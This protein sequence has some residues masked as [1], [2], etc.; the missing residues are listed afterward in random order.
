MRDVCSISTDFGRR[1]GERAL[2]CVEGSK[3]AERLA[4][5]AAEQNE[6]SHQVLIEPVRCGGTI[7]NQKYILTA[8]HC[9]VNSQ[10]EILKAKDL[11]VIVGLNSLGL[12][13]KASN[14]KAVNKVIVH[15]NYPLLAENT[16]PH[17]Y[18][19]DIALLELDSKISLGATTTNTAL[20]LAEKDFKPWVYHPHGVVLGL[21]GNRTVKGNFKFSKDACK[22]GIDSGIHEQILCVGDVNEGKPLLGIRD[23]GFPVI[24]RKNLGVPVL[25]GLAGFRND[26]DSC[27]GNKPDENECLAGLYT[28]VG[29]FKEWVEGKAGAQEDDTFPDVRLYGKWESGREYP[30]NVQVTSTQGEACGG[31][32]VQPNIVITAAHCVVN[33]NGEERQGVGVIIG[34]ESKLSDGKKFGVEG[35]RVLPGYEKCSHVNKDK[36]HFHN[37]LAIVKLNGDVDVRLEQLPGLAVGGEVWREGVELAWDS[38]DNDHRVRVTEYKVLER[39]ECERRKKRAERWRGVEMKQNLLCGVAAY[40]G[41]STCDRESGG[42]LFCENENGDP[43]LCGVNVLQTCGSSFPNG[44]INLGLYNSWIEWEI[45][46]LQS[47]KQE[48]VGVSYPPYPGYA[49]YD[50]LPRK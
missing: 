36:D 35:I 5:I 19:N 3:S 25:C 44:F 38:G 17:S 32:L 46:G 21:V 7:Y 33:S 27:N 41:G 16:K 14:V 15:E 43:V 39:E 45:K 22:E 6:F 13:R 50:N 9:V 29:Y 34:Q 48:N 1:Q 31:T 2:C 10:G 37:D 24:C 20:E 8:A 47:K 11:K 4:T 12:D 49:A 23:A 30:N 40:S 18:E 28:N 42:G 26:R